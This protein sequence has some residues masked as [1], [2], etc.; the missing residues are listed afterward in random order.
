MQGRIY[1]EIGLPCSV[2]LASN[3][4]VA[5]VA[6][7]TGKPK[8]F[9]TV[10][11]GEEAAFLA[12]LELRILPGIGPKTAKKLLRAFGSVKGVRGATPEDLEALVGPAAAAKITA[13]YRRP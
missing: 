9:V 12:P 10:H 6:C 1:V 8:G 2:G 7:E 3:K 13:F 4:L 5:K 11:P